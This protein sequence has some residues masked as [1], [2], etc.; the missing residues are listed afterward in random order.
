MRQVHTVNDTI[1]DG[2]LSV[3]VESF[4]RHLKAEN[5]APRTLKTYIEAV[6]LFGRFLADKGMPTTVANITR[7]HVEAFMGHILERWKPATAANRYR[8]LQQFFRWLEEEGELTSG[9]PMAKMKPPR[10][11]EEPP[12]VLRE[13]DLRAL[14]ATCEKGRDYE[15][16]RDHALIRV[17]IDTGARLGEIAGLRLNP[18]DD[19]NNDID[20]DQGVLRVL[21]KGRRMRL[22][23]L[24]NKAVR[25]LDRYLR[26]RGRHDRA[27]TTALW[28]GYKGPMTDS[29][30][31]QVLRR[32]GRQA[33]FKSQL[34]PHQLRHSAAHAWLAEG[35]Q[36]SDL[37][38]IMGW[39]SPAMLR[40]YA[41]STATERALA[42]HKRLGLGDRL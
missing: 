33:G 17:F 35:G 32:R 26:V 3:N 36:E 12:D 28:L 1:S 10:V 20:L 6:G 23:P 2:D 30:I 38:K 27:D 15:S 34:H 37:M 42:A 7:E 9:N 24:G 14:L 5:L 41:S 25:A 31:R 4:A 22:V 13:D 18:D 19:E 39:R 16:R 29:G 40:R 8:S 21:G 11:P